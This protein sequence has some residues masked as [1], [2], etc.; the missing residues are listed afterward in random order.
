MATSIDNYFDHEH[1]R[2]NT[3]AAKFKSEYLLEIFGTTNLYPFWIA[4]QDFK[5]PPPIL[6]ALHNRVDEGIF[7]YE[8]RADDYKSIQA[9]WYQRRYSCTIKP[10]WINTIPTIM[11]GM[12]MVLDLFT[13]KTGKVIKQPPV[14]KEFE[15]TIHKTGRTTVNN[16][17]KIVDLRYEM[18]LENLEKKVSNNVIEA[19]IICNPHNPVGRVWTPLELQKI[20]S[21]CLANNVLVISDEI[22]ADIVFTGSEFTSMLSFPEI[23]DQLIVLYSPSKLFNIASICDAICII[24]NPQKR[25][26][27]ENLQNRYNLGRPNAFTQVA[28]TVGYSKCDDWINGLNQY[29]EDNVSLIS[30]YLKNEIP[31]LKLIKQDGTFLIWVDIT[32]LKICSTLLIKRLA[33]E[34]KIGVSDGMIFG[35]KGQQFIRMNISCTRKT[36]QEALTNLKKYVKKHHRI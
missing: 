9:N 34:A 14:Y 8:C 26:Q 17:L 16:P 6:H 20:V 36:I 24:P 27:F 13:T 3:H 7:G 1:N 5:C 15:N 4:D 28:T 29:L 21:I 10:E 22:H 19:I 31:E 23:H 18:D 30:Y 12:A 11:T 35:E 25:V 32:E 2:F 33:K